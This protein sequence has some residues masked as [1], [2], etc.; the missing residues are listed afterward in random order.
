[1]L[2]MQLQDKTNFI[3]IDQKKIIKRML[4]YIF[5]F[6]SMKGTYF[7]ELNIVDEKEIQIINSKFRKKNYVTDVITFSM[8]DSNSSIRTELLGEIF[9]CKEKVISQAKEYNHSVNR[10][11]MFLISHGIFHLLGYDHQTP[12]D[13]KEMINNQY[14]VLEYLNIGR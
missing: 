14:N 12:E 3:T 4:A 11:L 7:F 13:E 8:W 9:L 5:K 10:E 2:K 6:E 1:M